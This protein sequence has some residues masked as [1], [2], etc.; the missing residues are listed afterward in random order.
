[1]R[2]SGAVTLRDPVMPI[3]GGFSGGFVWID[4]GELGE[5]DGHLSRS[6]LSGTERSRISVACVDMWEPFTKSI[7]KWAPECLSHQIGAG[8]AHPLLTLTVLRSTER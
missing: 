5:R 4:G 7:L 8:A 2:K 3:T 6:G 1:M